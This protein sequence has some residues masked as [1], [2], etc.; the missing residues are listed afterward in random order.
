MLNITGTIQRAFIFP[1][2]LD[3]AL[4]Y[5]SNLVQLAEYMPHIH[6]VHV[7]SPTE[8]RTLYETV[9]LGSYTIR[10]YSDL[11]MST[12]WDQRKLHVFPVRIESAPII[13]EIATMRE[14]TGTG[15]MAIDA[16]FSPL[17]NGQTHIEYN[18]RM[19]ANLQ[20]PAGMR[21]M[22]KRVVNRIAQSVT[23]SRLSEMVDGFIKISLDEFESWQRTQ[24]QLFS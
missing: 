21:M 11:A 5:Y 2:P 15:L 14:S 9:E 23:E 19:K 7:Y 10:V 4:R 8:I 24:K 6:L 1:A 12:N 20:R 13:E 3:I 18:I 22:P 17:E 16:D